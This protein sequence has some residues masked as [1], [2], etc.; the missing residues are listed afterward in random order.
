MFFE[1]AAQFNLEQHF[2]HKHPDVR[3][4][5]RELFARTKKA[6]LREREISLEVVLLIGRCPNH[7]TSNLTF[8]HRESTVFA[9]IK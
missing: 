9:R 1:K 3:M 4:Q 7:V 6:V 8:K 5:M 2:D